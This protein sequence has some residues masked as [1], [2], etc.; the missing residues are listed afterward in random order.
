MF[1]PQR[2]F[3]A[4]CIVPG[5]G[6]YWDAIVGRVPFARRSQVESWLSKSDATIVR[7]MG[8]G[9][10][11]HNLARD[12]M[13]GL[14]QDGL[15]SPRELEDM[16]KR[17]G[18]P[19]FQEAPDSSRFNPLEEPVWTLPMVL[20]WLVW[21]TPEA[22]RD[23]WDYYRTK[24]WHWLS[25]SRRLPING[26][27][28][29]REVHG[30]ELVV[31]RPASA[32]ELSL[33]EVFDEA[34]GETDICMSV[35]SAREALWKSLAAGT[36]AANATDAGGNVLTIP[37]REWAY[38]EL[39][40]TIDG[41][42]YLINRQQSLQAAYRNLTFTRQDVVRLWRPLTGAKVGSAGAPFEYPHEDRF[43]PLIAACIWVGAEG[44]SLTTAQIADFAL[45]ETGSGKLFDALNQNLLKATGMSRDLVREDIPAT[46]WEMATLDPNVPGHFV[47]F[48]DETA[49]GFWGTM[50]PAGYSAPRWSRINIEASALKKV[51][52][53]AKS[54]PASCRKWLESE[55][56]D[57][58]GKRPRTKAEYLLISK[59]RYSVKQ[60]EFERGWVNALENVPEAKASWTKGGRPKKR[61]VKFPPSK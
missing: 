27:T 55:M 61:S 37:V 57:S 6:E 14:A 34:N 54:Q 32:R 9:Q 16:A 21:R 40:H 38:L 44:Q 50:T 59:E 49:N 43:W 20:A 48:V 2:P 46:Y 33:S 30:H 17:W 35:K 39:A 36:I 45:D 24:C 4:D 1:F 31:R 28:S 7:L 18:L 12:I 22:V 56:R 19:P 5:L 25:F 41:P 8:S 29:W 11:L 13:L 3:L 51:F 42:D 15:S 26:G 10:K 23:E 60:S 58:P 47:N 52:P 53:F